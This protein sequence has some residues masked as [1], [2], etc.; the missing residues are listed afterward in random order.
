MMKELTSGIVLSGQIEAGENL[1]FGEVV[2]A[3]DTRFE[4]GQHVYF[5]KYSAVNVID[6][7]SV[8]DGKISLSDAQKESQIICAQDD[9]MAYDDRTVSKT[10]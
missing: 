8:L 1:L 9:V 6:Y 4:K 3:G 2:H 7:Q 5:S 10:S